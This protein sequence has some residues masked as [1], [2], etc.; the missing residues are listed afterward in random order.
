MDF[1]SFW[2]TYAPKGPLFFTTGTWNFDDWVT[3]LMNAAPDIMY[4]FK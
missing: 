2:E 3:R 1:Q 4:F